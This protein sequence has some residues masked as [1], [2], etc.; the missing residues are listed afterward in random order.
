MNTF[1]AVLATDGDATY[2]MFLYRDIQWS[3]GATSVGF[4]AGDG[5]RGFNLLESSITE[6]SILDLTRKSNVGPDYP[7][8]YI[9]R[10]DQVLEGNYIIAN[11]IHIQ[12]TLYKSG[13]I[14]VSD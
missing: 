6:G 3:S 4:N 14:R 12:W 7:G 8:V 9:F 13:E 11:M 10:V 2:V 5:I 1:Q